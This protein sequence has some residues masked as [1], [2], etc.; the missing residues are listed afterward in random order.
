MKGH[1]LKVILNN[2]GSELWFTEIPGVSLPVS[3]REPLQAGLPS[4]AKPPEFPPT[5]TTGL[6]TSYG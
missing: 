3:C 1:K 2:Q 4:R 6:T 5:G